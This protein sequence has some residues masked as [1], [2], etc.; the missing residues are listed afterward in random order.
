MR[1]AVTGGTGYIGAHIVRQLLT[2]GHEVRL[3]VLPHERIEDLLA[4][5]AGLG[6]VSTVI[7]DVRSDEVLKTL[8]TDCDSLVHAAGIV[9]TDDSKAELM[10]EINAH[11][12][13]RALTHAV[14]AGLDPV[15]L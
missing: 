4:S 14:A 9:G 5:F 2:E 13:D 3:L 6:T 11:A 15:V 10:W 7:G 8:M 12:S 1:V